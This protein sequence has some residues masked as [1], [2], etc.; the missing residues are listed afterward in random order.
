MSEIVIRGIFKTKKNYAPLETAKIRFLES[1]LG[2]ETSYGLIV[3][4][5]T[6]QF[7]RMSHYFCKVKRGL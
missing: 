6:L 5:L 7:K 4:N 3:L 1:G 2:I